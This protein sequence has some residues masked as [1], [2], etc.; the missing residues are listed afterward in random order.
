MGKVAEEARYVSGQT[1]QRN[2]MPMIAEYHKLWST[3][4]IEPCNRKGEESSK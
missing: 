3:G 2:Q 1:G 4:V